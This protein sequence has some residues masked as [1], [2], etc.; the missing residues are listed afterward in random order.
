MTDTFN[1]IFFPTIRGDAKKEEV[2]A[3]LVSTLKVDS[4]KVEA[5]FTSGKPTLLLKNVVHDVADRYMQAI[6]KCGGSC[7]LQP[8]SENSSVLSLTPKPKNIEFFICPSCDYGEEIPLGTTQDEC[9]ECGLIIESYETR[10]VNEKER[11]E[12]RRRL[13]RD[14]RIVE[15]DVNEE[16][17]KYEELARVRRLENEIMVD[18]GMRPAGKLWQYFTYHPVVVF[19]VIYVLLFAT[20]AIILLFGVRYLA[21]EKERAFLAGEPSMQIQDLARVT[22]AAVVLKQNENQMVLQEF[23]ETTQRLRGRPGNQEEVLLTATQMMRGASPASFLQSAE[24]DRIRLS[25]TPAGP[26]EKLSNVNLDT[27]GGVRGISGI[28]YFTP[29]QLLMVSAKAEQH[30]AESVLSMLGKKPV[31]SSVDDMRGQLETLDG[32]TVINLIKKLSADYEWDRFLLGYVGVYTQAGL[33]EDASILSESIQNP[34]TKIAALGEIMVGQVS[35]DQDVNLDLGHARVGLEMEKISDPETVARLWSLLGKKLVSEG[36]RN[37][38]KNTMVRMEKLVTDTSDLYAK[39]VIAARYAV[40][41]L[42][43]F[44]N[45]GARKYFSVATDSAGRVTDTAMRISAFV[46]IAQ[47]YY[48]ARNLTLASEILYEAQILAATQ[49]KTTKR[50]VLLGEI[51]YAQCYIGDVSGALLSV[52]NASTGHARDQLRGKLVETLI[53]QDK[54]YVAREILSHVTDNVEASRL[55]LRLVSHLFH[56]ENRSDAMALLDQSAPRVQMIRQPHLK[57]LLLSQYA[58]MY[59]RLDQTGVAE[60]YFSVATSLSSRLSGRTA[61]VVT[62]MVAYNQAKALQTRKSRGTLNGIRISVIGDPFSSEIESTEKIIR[63]FQ[64]E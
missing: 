12:I 31:V 14:A 7:N 62:G 56:N 25:M 50:S 47:R 30:G 61:A 1:L 57:A 15:E 29:D 46:K 16:S 8:S 60:Q 52:D 13:I 9:P 55:T 17:R 28:E 4:N 27:L 11:D 49:L 32:S 37:E 2:K 54:V 34:L 59:I 58:R 6:I 48:D 10:K 21:T 42:S 22:A 35:R 38:P 45:T 33:F 44:D 36:A 18:L 23:A 41:R 51:A 53:S 26:G 20:S 63:M 19:S 40:M 24:T 39:S 43:F 64:L 5:W 3:N